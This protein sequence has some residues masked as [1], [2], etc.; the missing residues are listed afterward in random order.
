MCRCTSWG[1]EVKGYYNP[2]DLWAACRSPTAPHL[3]PSYTRNLCTAAE[4]G[5]Q[6]SRNA[7]LYHS[8]SFSFCR[9]SYAQSVYC[10]LQIMGNRGQ[11]MR[12]VHDWIL[13]NK[14]CFSGPVYGPLALEIEM[15][16]GTALFTFWELPGNY[17]SQ[18]HRS[19]MAVQ[20]RCC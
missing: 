13:H 10:F 14:S 11:G 1:I 6:G 3:F 9:T 16:P 17:I 2:C 20:G 7:L 12:E 19:C 5:G 15:L 18:E 8:V 4:H